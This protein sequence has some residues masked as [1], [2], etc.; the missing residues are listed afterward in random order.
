MKKKNR[1]FSTVFTFVKMLLP[2]WIIII[3]CVLVKVLFK[4][5]WNESESW[6]YINGHTIPSSDLLAITTFLFGTILTFDIHHYDQIEPKYQDKDEQIGDKD[7]Y[8]IYKGEV[9]AQ[10][11]GISVMNIALILQYFISFRG[12]A[13]GFTSE[14][15]LLAAFFGDILYLVCSLTRQFAKWLE[16]LRN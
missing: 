9:L 10:L 12:M 8:R 7:K 3:S 11:I 15:L 14:E 16:N 4:D 1:F 5:A 6:F 13:F 2:I